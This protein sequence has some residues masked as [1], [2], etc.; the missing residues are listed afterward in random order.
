MDYK[1]SK[2]YKEIISNSINKNKQSK[3]NTEVDK[4]PTIRRRDEIRM[5]RNEIDELKKD[6]KEMLRLMNALYDFETQEP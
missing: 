1:S 2:L 3:V 4:A 6:V 5:M